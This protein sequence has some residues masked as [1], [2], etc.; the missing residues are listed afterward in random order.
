[1]KNLKE[2]KVKEMK[3]KEM[4][5]KE[6]KA[7]RLA[8][9]GGGLILSFMLLT[10][11]QSVD[12]AIPPGTEEEESVRVQQESLQEQ[13]TAQT[14]ETVEVLPTL[15]AGGSSCSL[16]VM[17]EDFYFY[18]ED[19]FSIKGKDGV[20]VVGVNHNSAMYTGVG[21]DVLSA[22]DRVETE[23]GEM[24]LFEVGVV[25][26]APVESNVAVLLTGVSEEQ[27]KRGDIVVLSGSGH[28]SD[29]AGVTLTL[30]EPS[31]AEEADL[32]KEGQSIWLELFDT[33]VEA[34]IE[35]VSWE[36]GTDQVQVTVSFGESIAFMDGQSVMV[37]DAQ[38]KML[39]IAYL[40]RLD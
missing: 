34:V 37:Y 24:E 27:V 36:Q 22:S 5:A 13:E 25:D 12:K 39:G 17:S 32:L 1:M 23:I 28:V 30:L 38:E 21:V 4:K 19:V 18:I 11:C 35:T 31:G 40:T 3:V 14:R 16:G 6:R 7:K 2:M 8:L 9:T 20:V 26:T 15:P 29:Q 10:G 33:P